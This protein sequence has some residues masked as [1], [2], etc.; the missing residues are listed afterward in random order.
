MSALTS[1]KNQFP[2]TSEECELL[3]EFETVP[4]LTEVAKRV[5]RDHS[6][7][8]RALK[9]IGER[10]PVVE[11]RAGRWILTEMGRKLNDCTRASLARQSS[12]LSSQAALRIGTNREFASRVLAEDILAIQALFP[13]TEL[14][15]NSYEA[16]TELPLLQG[17]IDIGIDC[18]RPNDPE[19]SYKLVVDEPIIAV[20]SKAFARKHQKE[21]AKQSYSALPHILC[22]RLNPDKFMEKT[23]SQVRIAARFNDIA[24]AR[25]ACL[26]GL[27]W[28]L[29]PRYAVKTEL[30]AGD[31]VQIQEMTMVRYK[32]GIWWPRRRT[33]LKPTVESLI[34]WLGRKTL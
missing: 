12:V 21:I 25:A 11:K 6:V 2:L 10:Y 7:V 9:R 32:Y 28:A 13:N 5:G 19:I 8:A 27:G 34:A 17:Q 24:A 26:H 30:E 31:L 20:A 29:L 33:Y 4:S 18:D 16:G 22:E 23:E 1:I 3:L 15:V 14:C